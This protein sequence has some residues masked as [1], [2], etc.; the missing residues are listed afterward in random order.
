MNPLDLAPLIVVIASMVSLNIVY[1]RQII[2]SHFDYYEELRKENTELSN[3][4]ARL[5]NNRVKLIQAYR[6]E[7][8]INNQLR[9]QNAALVQR[10]ETV[11]KLVTSLQEKLNA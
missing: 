3:R 11:E 8:L 4:V 2:R 6:K 10:V 7:R 1:Y 5:E 9:S